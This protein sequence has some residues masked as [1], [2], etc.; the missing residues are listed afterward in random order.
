MHHRNYAFRPPYR[1]KDRKVG[2]VSLLSRFLVAYLRPY[3]WN[4]A[5]CVLLATLDYAG[6]FYLLAYYN[7]VVVDSILVVVPPKSAPANP[8][9]ISVDSKLQEHD[10][11][12]TGRERGQEQVG[13]AQVKA[14]LDRRLDTGTWVSWRPAG[15]GHRL[16]IIFVLYMATLA[17]SNLMTRIA[18]RQRIRMTQAIT[19]DLRADMHAKVLQLSLDYQASHTPGRLMARILS[20]VNMVAEHMMWI[21]INGSSMLAIVVFGFLLL[22]II[23]WR[24][25]VIVAICSPLYVI[26]YRTCRPHLNRVN[27]ELSHTNACLYGLVS[28]KL[29]ATKMIQ[30]YGREAKESLTFHRLSSCFLRDALWQNRLGGISGYSSEIISGLASNG[31]LFI[32]GIF[33][34]IN[35]AITLGQMMYAWGTASAL[36]GPVLQL[37]YMNVTISNLL[38]YLNRLAEVLDEPVKIKDAPDA[39]DLPVPLKQGISLKHVS[40]AYSRDGAPVLR[41]ISLEV[42]AG[43]WAC[44]MGASGTGKTTL[45]HLLARMFEPD[46]GEILY[47]GIPMSKIRILSLRQRLALVPQ[48]ANIISGTIRDNICYGYP[49]AEPKDII[50]AARAAEFHD[51]IMG[52]QVQYETILGE[53]GASLSGGQRQ[54]L[55]LARALLTKPEILLLDDC[56]SA[57]DAEIEHRIQETLSRILVGKTAVIVTQRV[58]MAQRC[59][60]VYVLDKGVISEQGTHAELMAQHG[61][62][63]RLVARQTKA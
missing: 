42:P 40:F 30:A 54:R 1:Q 11:T 18:A 43:Q 5:L 33:R 38:V 36:F 2:K 45:L 31:I 6:S 25:A 29:D 24:M 9:N 56:T 52:M 14:G 39:V 57:L 46:K 41:D 47:D 10:I 28:Q 12:L 51:F 13:H 60:R 8:K 27:M 48:E 55:S 50:A 19:A 44:I 7:K 49:D 63:A 17:L 15:A 4:L 34:V 32:H 20:D 22:T 53:K 35:G 3:R 62:Y 61:F 26:I 23:D 59:H 16:G 21:I 58:S 37:G